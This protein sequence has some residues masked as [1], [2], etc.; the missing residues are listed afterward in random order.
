MRRLAGCLML[1]GLSLSADRAGAAYFTP[2]GDLTGGTFNS[3]AGGVS[4]DGSVVVGSSSSASGFEAFRWTSGGMVGLGDLTGDVFSSSA[5]GVSADGS[6]VVGLSISASGWEAFRWTSGSGMVGLGD[7]DGGGFSSRAMVVSAD[8]SVVVGQGSSAAGDEAFRWTSGDGMLGL[9][10]LAGGAFDSK[11]RGVSGDGSVVVGNSRTAAGD[12]AFQWTSGGGMVGLGDLTGGGFHS[13][14]MGISADGSVVVGYGNSSSGYEAFRWTSSGGMVGLGDLT[15]GAEYYSTADAASADGSV[16]VGTGFTGSAERAFLWTSVMGVVNLYD[17][18]YN[19]SADDDMV[20]WTLDHA[21]D[22]SNSG[23]VIVGDGRNPSGDTEAW[24]ISL[25]SLPLQWTNAASGT[26]D[27]SGNWSYGFQPGAVGQ[28]DV[29]IQPDYGL[30]VAGPLSTTT[31]KSL[32]VDARTAGTAALAIQNTGTLIVT[33]LTTVGLRGKLTGEGTLVAGGGIVNYGQIDLG[34]GGLQIVGGTLTNSGFIRGEGQ[35][36]NTLVNATDG[37]LWGETGKLLLLTGPANTNGGDINLNGGNIVFAQDLTNNLEGFIGGRGMLL[38]NGGLTNDGTLG[39]S[40]ALTDIHGDVTNNA[41]AKIIVSGGATLTFYD[42]LANE[43]ELRMGTGC[44]TVIFGNLSGGGEVNGGTIYI[45]G[46]IS[47]G[48][49]P[50]DVFLGG[51]LVLGSSASLEIELGGILAGEEYDLLNV[52]GLVSLD[53]TLDV[54]LI[55]DF[56]PRPGQSFTVMT[57][58]SREGDFDEY[59]GLDLTEGLWLEPSFT[60]HALV[61][62][63]VP[64]PS[65]LLMLAAGAVGLL[66]LI[67]R[68]RTL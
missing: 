32:T 35:I 26:W 3:S 50:G 51:D 14:A 11:A 40:G 27:T 9:G 66:A 63:T 33:E 54:K 12:E 31:V 19:I 2:L 7:L 43:G 13:R 34:D 25:E 47:P 60:P 48:S 52:G 20:G 42:D 23:R 39:F 67:R 6:V 55:D 68:R 65:T 64:E 24:L 62:V 45:E 22:T 36:D 58:G 56:T 17:F 8:G 30:T 41:D 21:R 53:G 49:S 57:F 10:D 59:L 5:T 29:L 61:L 15:G 37:Q 1:V 16:I 46:E 4:A 18:V 44:S 38:V 28:D